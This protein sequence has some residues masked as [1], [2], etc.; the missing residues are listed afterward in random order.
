MINIEKLN[1]IISLARKCNDCAMFHFE[2]FNKNSVNFKIDNSPVTNADLEVNQIAVNGLQKLFPDINIV[3]EE[4][5]KSQKSFKN[6]KLFWLIDPIDGTK[7]YINSS[8][9][10][11]VNFALIQNQSPIFGLISQPFTGL[12]WYSFKGKAWKIKKKQNI[13]DAKQIECSMVNYDKLHILSSSNHRS[14]ELDNWISI[15]NPISD[16]HI[17]SSIKFC[18]MAEGKVDLYPRTS[19][20]MEW[21]IAAGH[22]ILKAAGGNIVSEFGLEIQYGKINFRNKKFLAF[23]RIKQRLPSKIL[24]CLNKI[25]IDKYEYDLN[26]GVKALTNK[27]LLIFPTETVYGI[28]SI[29]NSKEAIKSIYLAKKRP[30]NNPLIAHTF[31]KNEAEKHVEFTENAHLLTNNFW[32]GPLTVVLQTKKSKLSDILSQGKSSLAIRVPSHPVALDLLEKIRIP[33]LAPS[34]N[35]SGGVSPTSA[36]HSK[37]DF[38]PEFEGQGWKLE[39]ILDYG[40]CEIGIESTVVD[41]RGEHPIILR[42]GFITSDMIYN[43]TKA[44]VLNVEDNEDLI[45]PGQLKSHY[46]PNAKVYLNQKIN[47]ENSGWLTFGNPPKLLQKNQNVFNLSNEENIIQ[48]CYLLYAGLRYLDTCGVKIIQV[49]PIPKKGIG[50]A[51]NDRLTRAAHKQ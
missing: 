22:S 7:E 47:I 9:N 43:V 18:Y 8:P 45:S 46:S 31:S 38:G 2:T 15:V 20:T 10:F 48:A 26:L 40:S 51:I 21:D 44:E 4:S 35:K 36:Q 28:G 41:C 32:P 19:P 49:M 25:N 17:G 1:Q 6:N 11:T 12:I 24:L 37:N 34:A 30:F 23:G 27:N 14:S 5:N 29:G 50:I 33:V 16:R 39:R 42:H 13:D 3:S